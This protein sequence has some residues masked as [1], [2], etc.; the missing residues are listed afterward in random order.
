[1]TSHRLGSFAFLAATLFVNAATAG[2]YSLCIGEYQG[3]GACPDGQP[4]YGCGSDPKDA[5]RE[6]CAQEGSSGEPI[7]VHLA[8]KGGNRCGYEFYQITCQ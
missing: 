3:R 7:V 8:S 2:T 4:A 5:A 6:L 1:M